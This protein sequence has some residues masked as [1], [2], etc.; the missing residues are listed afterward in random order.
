MEK[1]VEFSITNHPTSYLNST[2]VQG[3]HLR[4]GKK[5]IHFFGTGDKK[6]FLPLY[7]IFQSLNPQHIPCS[8]SS[9]LC[10]ILYRYLR[11]ELLIVLQEFEK[12]FVIFEQI[13]IMLMNH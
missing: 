8:F 13:M 2:N 6:S 5:T 7:Q 10:I 9:I 1:F 4:V 3:I 11:I 12:W